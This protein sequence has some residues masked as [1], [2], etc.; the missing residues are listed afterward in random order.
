MTNEHPRTSATDAGLASS[1]GSLLVS[2][3][4]KIYLVHQ[5]TLQHQDQNSQSS[6]VIPGSK[7]EP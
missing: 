6:Q 5:Y 4:P 2:S 1:T 7:D 3:L